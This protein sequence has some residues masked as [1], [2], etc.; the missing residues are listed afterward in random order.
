MGLFAVLNSVWR[1]GGSKALVEDQPASGEQ[2]KPVPRIKV[3]RPHGHALALEP[4][5]MFDG[6][7]ASAVDHQNGGD[8]TRPPE[9]PSA[10][11][12]A[13]PTAQASGVTAREPSATAEAAPAAVAAP[14]PSA[15]PQHLL[16]IDSRVE[17][18]EQLQAQTGP[19]VKV[20]VVDN[21]QD[22]LAAIS[23][24][25]AQMG[26]VDSIQILSHGG[27][28]QFTLGSRN[29]SADNIDQLGA[30]LQGWQPHLTADADIQLYG[31]SVGAGVAGQTLVD[32]LAR[33]TGA[34][35]GASSDATGAAADG[36]N[37][38]LETRAGD[39]DKPLVLGA[40][41]LATFDGLLADAMPQVSL[42]AGGDNV[43]LGDTFTFT[44]S[45]TNGSE[46]VGYAPYIDV[47]VPTTGKD[48]AGAEI[49][50]GVTLLSATFQGVQI[51]AYEVVFDPSGLATHPLAKGPDGQ[52][53]VI[54]AAQFGMRAGDTLWVLQLP[55]ASITQGQ[56]AID[57]VVTLQLSNL[58]DT[59]LTDT[60][61]DLTIKAR[62]GF[63]FGNTSA[64]DPTADPTLIEAVPHDFVVH[65]TMVD[66]TMTANVPEGQT[67]TGPNYPR[68][69]T[70]TASTASDQSLDDVVVGQDLP[71]DIIVTSIVP[72]TGGTVT[73]I[74]LQDGTVITD[75][76]AIATTLAAGAYLKH[77][78]VT[79][80]SLT[81]SVDTTVNFYV[82]EVDSD[83]TPVL[84]PTTGAP[85]TITIDGPEATAQWTPLDTRDTLLDPDAVLS[86]SGDP[87]SFQVLS[88]VVYKTPT[89]T[90]DT[91]T[92]GAS[93][94][95]TL[96]YTLQVDISDYFAFG[97]NVLNQ[98]TLVITDAASDGQTVVADSGRF[99]ATINGVQIDVAIAPASITVDP[100]TGVTTMTLDLAQTMR[101][102][103]QAL[104][105]LVG[106][107]AFD[108]ANDGATTATI[109]YQT[110]ID[111]FYGPPNAQSAIN[112][113]DTV[114][115]DATVS[116]T[117][118]VDPVT[119]G[120]T[121]SDNDTSTVTITPS[122]VDIEVLEVDDVDVSADPSVE[123]RPGN[124]VTFQVSY[125]LVTGDYQN[126]SLRVY[127][128]LPLFDVN[129]ITWTV[130][131]GNNQW[132]TGPDHTLLDTVQSVTSVADGNYIV[133]DF[134]DHSSL[135]NEGSR[136]ELRFTMTV[137]DTPFGDQRKVTVIAQSDQVTTLGDTHIISQ[138]AAVIDSIAEPV[139]N[140]SHGVVSSSN[141]TVTGAGDNGWT[142]PDNT[143]DI[144]FTAPVTEITDVNG[145]VSGIDG[146]D[147]LRMATAI[148]N[149]GG[150][151]AYDV[152][153]RIDLPPGLAF[154][155]AGLA[156]TLRIYR[157]DG[158]L[159]VA[160]T[161]YEVV[162]NVV[163]FLD[164]VEAHGS[165]LAGRPDTDPDN[166]GQN[167]VVLVYDVRVSDTIA[168]SSTL[169]TTATLTN[170][171]AVDEGQDF[172]PVDLIE[173]AGEQ[174]AAPGIT[175]VY[176]DGSLTDDDSSAT[177]TT[178]ANLVI[179]ETMDYDIVVTLPEG[180]TTNLRIDDLIPSGLALDM[181]FG[182][183]AGY[184]IILLQSQSGAL[185]ADFAGTIAGQTA[186]GDAVGTDGADA[187]LSFTASVNSAD[188][189]TGNNSFVIRVRLVASNSP[190][191][192]QGRSLGNSAQLVYEDPDGDVAGG[193]AG[194]RTV[195]L[196]SGTPSV[197]VVEPTLT[198]T[199][200]ADPLPQFGVDEGD[201]V[202]YTITIG[203]TSGTD[204]FDLAFQETFPTA[205]I[206][207][208]TL[209]SVTYT[210]PGGAT[211]DITASFQLVDG[212]LSSLGTADIDLP[213]GGT[214]VILV[215]GT[216]TA[217]A[218]NSQTIDSTA[219]VSWTS[220]D[221]TV[222]VTSAGGERT[223]A[224]GLLDTGVL[225]DYQAESVIRV[226]VLSGLQLS[227]IG[228]MVDTPPAD[229]GTAGDNEQ[230]AVGEIVRYRVVSA[231]GE[232]T[233]N[234][235]Q[236]RVVLD[237][238]LTFANDGTIRIAIVS[239]G[240]AASVTSTLLL[241][242]DGTLYV[243]GDRT[244]A[245]A[246]PIPDD[247]DGPAPTALIAVG[248]VIVDPTD[249][250]IVTF[251][252]GT[253][254]NSDGDDNLE[255][256]VI[257]FN[258]R[259]AN[260]ASN[261]AGAALG[262]TASFIREGGVVGA[263]DSATEIVVE[264]AFSGMVKQ[265]DTFD[266]VTTDGD[267]STA[268]ISVRFTQSGGAPAYDV[269]L[270]DS[271]AGLVG[272]GRY[273]P[274]RIS[275]GGTEYV[276]G[277]DTL[278]DG[279]AFT[280]NGDG[281]GITVTFDRI[282]Q[283]TEVIVYY[284]VAVDA[285][286]AYA[287]TDAVL[288]WSSL[289][290]SFQNLVGT[291]V[292]VDGAVDGERDGSEAGP[293][294][295]VLREGAGL[296]LIRGQLW[297]DSLGPDGSI[298][299]GEALLADQTVTLVWGGAD[300]VVGT[301]GDDVTFTTITDSAGFFQFSGL[302]AGGYQVQA[303]TP[304]TI[305]TPDLGAVRVRFDTDAN[306]LGQVDAAVEEGGTNAADFGYVQLNDAPVNTVP[307]A[308]QVLEDEVLA[309]DNG[310]I[311][312]VGDVDLDNGP[313]AGVLDVTL[314]VT[315]GM[316]N[317]SGAPPTDLITAG[318]LGGATITLSGTAAQ[319][320]DALLRLTYQGVANYNGSDV[321]RITTKD[322]GSF[323]DNPD[324]ALGD[325]IPGQLADELTDE[326]TV[327]INVQAVNDIPEGVN[328]AAIAVE[329]GGT[330]NQTPGRDPTGN[331]LDN[332]IDV[333]KAD[334]PVPDV[335][336]LT[337]VTNEDGTVVVLIDADDDSSTEHAIQGIHGTLYVRANGVARYVVDNDDPD[338]QALRTADDIRQ[339]TFTYTLADS[340][341]ADAPAPATLTVTIQGANDTPVGNDDTGTAV[342]GV[343]GAPGTPATGNV[344]LGDS[345]GGVADTDVD[346]VDFGET[347]RVTGIRN[348]AKDEAG[349]LVAVMAGTDTVIA[350]QYGTLT[351][352]STGA[353]TYVVNEDA[354]NSLPAGAT[355]QDV[356]SYELSD[357]GNLSTLANL[358]IT[359]VGANDAPLATDDSAT[360][361]EA[362][363]LDN[364]TPGSDGEGLALANDTDPDTG[365]T[366]QLTVT[367]IR[368]GE[369]L[370]SGTD[371]TVGTRLQGQYG[372]LTIQAD[373]SY[374]YEV[375]NDDAAVQALRTT[376]NTLLDYFTYT[377]GDRAAGTPGI[378]SDTA[379]IIITIQGANDTPVAND[380]TGTAI[381]GVNG[382]PGTPATGNVVLG[383][384]T[385]GVA[386]TDVDSV[387]NGETQR[388]SGIRTGDKAGA[389]GFTGVDG[390]AG[391]TVIAGQYGTLT[392]GASGAYTYVVDEDA[393]NSLPAGATLEDV[394][395]YQ[396]S[397]TGN[398]T[399]VAN[400]TIT[401][402]G[403]NDAPL[404]VDD[405]AVALEAGGTFNQTAGIDPQGNVLSNDSDPDTGDQLVVN[406]I[407][408]GT[409]DD[410]GPVTLVV[411]DTS[412][413][414]Q[415]GT[416]TIRGDGT[417]TYVVNNTL[418]AVQR[419][420]DGDSL[421]ETFSYHL[422]DQLFGSAV[423]QLVVTIDGA[424][425]APVAVD[426]SNYAVPRLI[427]SPGRDA[428]GN[429]IAG[430]PL[431]AGADSDVDVPD[432]S[433]VAGI[434]PG[435]EAVP[436]A[437]DGV[438]AG[439]TSADGTQVVGQYGRLTIG[440]DGSYVY[441][442]NPLNE[443]VLALQA[444]ESLIERFTYQSVDR[445]GLN[446]T[447]E[448]V[449][450]VFGR[451]NLPFPQPDSG[452][453]VE[454]GGLNND[455]PGV[456]PGG[457][458]LTNDIDLDPRDTLTVSAVRTGG[459]LE[460]G[461]DGVVGQPLRGTYG[462][463][464]VN[465][466]GTWTYTVDN[467]L[468]AVEALRTADQTL[469]ETFTYTASDPQGASR[470]AT[471]RIVIA[472][473]N[474][475]PIAQ[476]DGNEALEAGG[477]DNA[478]PGTDATGNVLDNDNDVDG[479]QYGETEQVQ[480]YAGANGA[481]GEAGSAVA[482]LYGQ[483]VINADGSYRYVI[484]N[485]N[486]A[487]Q[488]L[489]TSG[490]TL[491]E[492]FSYVMRDAAGA[493]SQANLVIVVRGAN[494]NPVARDDSNV[495]SDQV[496]APQAGGNVLPNDSDVDGGDA[497]HV[498]AV[499]TGAESGAGTTGALGQPLAGRYGTLVL[500]ADGSYTYAI[501][502]TN[503]EVLAAAGFGQILQDV[504]TYTV[505]DRA[506]ATDQ[507]QLVIHLDISAPRIDNGNPEYFGRDRFWPEPPTLGL[508][509]EPGL[510]V[511][512][513][514]RQSELQDY[515]DR[516]SASGTEIALVLDHYTLQPP[517]SFTY[518][519]NSVGGEFVGEVVRNN[520]LAA[521][522]ELARLLGRH[523][524]VS[525]TADGLLA[526][527]SLFSSS[528]ASL[529]VGP[530]QR[531]VPDAE[532]GGKRSPLA[533]AR[534]TIRVADAAPMP[535][536]PDNGDVQALPSAGDT[537]ALAEPVP[538]ATAS[539]FSEQL[540]RAAA[541]LHSQFF[542]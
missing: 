512:P 114:G 193:T 288:T 472:G 51:Q 236:I 308:Q 292:G 435:A 44:A 160:G 325:G 233:T 302:A 368:T 117:V 100:V 457:N 372:W 383:D 357:T 354:V 530:T 253:I 244:S 446:D 425:D 468:A 432:L 151:D 386:D 347:Q 510:F 272:A 184:E 47:F 388:V 83:G 145:D 18:R 164:P 407:R 428:V 317:F 318:T 327:D 364:T 202:N 248:R 167:L 144:P 23:D 219:N 326:D 322:R 206:S 333:D 376:G 479:V 282:D 48:G 439:T 328:D 35:V 79:Y 532:A 7:A 310:N 526:D 491:T 88:I 307:G 177:H 485:A 400:L 43:L 152:S 334:Q 137:S 221:D 339:E 291:D 374:V 395:S 515:T 343:N 124:V 330:N 349:D 448:L 390:S 271:F 338:V 270:V 116:G 481:Q 234:N 45:F 31:C 181:S 495:A 158:T 38:T 461:A 535:L 66:L 404:P 146:G 115:N 279:V 11:R 72:G 378:Q 465:A 25:L 331:L 75:T 411:G 409:R 189:D 172:T 482:G 42:S 509:V 311:I 240:G 501:D 523:G 513:V 430:G 455:R 382:A 437:F 33:W 224:D 259:V 205:L 235:Y 538:V 286:T 458:V 143:T 361:L 225:N 10:E 68:S 222:P 256:V 241:S 456:D 58:A 413:D 126:F 498:G 50:D 473:S 442:V 239:D 344:V 396:L 157:G 470:Q 180:T 5:V 406:G 360:A 476:D 46:Q 412:V 150:G 250:R 91:G 438:T 305:D 335:L 87:V 62:G 60:A 212:V 263:S 296:G 55:N 179:G 24:A 107:L 198:V 379:Q 113:G 356:F 147:T 220:L 304:V 441:V 453:A 489:R 27:A 520:A 475:T 427:D 74:T 192:Q 201:T 440:A 373:G 519:L 63:Q 3:L 129:G 92:P 452:D 163:T 321:L 401:I 138:D 14:A 477:I 199:Q 67:V 405:T 293:N 363:G 64:D 429:V 29:F 370:G 542:Q 153:T 478:T 257:E 421:T 414:G 226:P 26:Q 300:G 289:P 381:E 431:G 59:N 273:T 488:A 280:A 517:T 188:N 191:N 1:H 73:S 247:L 209:T 500:N 166:T 232:G 537:L 398:L 195:A 109:T 216:V 496:V 156:D 169:Q 96:T 69:I 319:I 251:D 450:T 90:D 98:G 268:D 210:A 309:F 104:A 15:A 340:A 380:D 466:D 541:Q 416:L 39:V 290:E 93:P 242:A 299:A 469:E 77:Y 190:E 121:A 49:D 56:P 462:T 352:G 369:E 460:S 182:G 264:P 474:D 353:Y 499:R 52:P 320:N 20:L 336:H 377:A 103:G 301:G 85:R 329:A 422:R 238:G 108:D 283:N 451:N 229:G 359:I 8:T 2:S 16:V 123:L 426:D 142:T 417:F 82:P 125:D 132:F 131:E 262:V 306:A 348:V 168:A 314:T 324:P 80:A 287:N 155:G 101:D 384:S 19:D 454:A 274:S 504:F 534:A 392:I 420:R 246:Q 71:N 161:D 54:N 13:A 217:E 118:L 312:S 36:G 21:S 78:E 480:A 313:T 111:Q 127:M 387:A 419:L 186:S 269:T 223:G 531:Q 278:P 148:E 84:D 516:L 355:L 494:D 467:S 402:V 258:A 367:A 397:D 53:L 187:R 483:I 536:A 275:I 28:G 57:I 86:G 6:A 445:G 61:P 521:Q 196:S 471:L 214:I 415:Y 444:G 207:G 518:G 237:E 323:G 128:P 249:S 95:D 194:D 447:A 315:H 245:I 298:G 4:R 135:I 533:Q 497:L 165:L 183:G 174:V 65:P 134:G 514:V 358:T 228:G 133:F 81:G 393:V 529:T 511:Q 525:L 218:D 408:A 105:A 267:G 175:K 281:T 41:T 260:I 403:A 141:G 285:N 30:Q 297:D 418:D 434:R 487:V 410:G 215:S 203:N 119:T 503:P 185:S 540:R 252:L 136:V 154:V 261:T 464:L 524:R 350:G 366:A 484:D 89:I 486:P 295:Y 459:L 342:E 34:D 337:S 99:V 70:V 139:L 436:G 97:R 507:A 110:T 94:G 522:L 505:V 200:T 539:A 102:N 527:P 371:G 227:R 32:E 463:L 433:T 303:P 443:E 394:F 277:V 276:I 490:E 294:T 508:Q 492:T 211:T 346:S 230:V 265:V 423:G 17:Q 106:D 208:M 171:A 40:E 266:P 120:E 528:A 9:A 316:L 506:G 162:D 375:N 243:T 22:G 385:G 399:A 76:G 345:T 176:R 254:T 12:S 149:S 231:I 159:L 449:I 341:G 493:V 173:L 37:W 122:Q 365:D 332:D 351:I 389:G 170:Y 424:W 284:T 204:A 362:G 502:L 140:I 130:G 255:G 197:V 178:G 391:D 213:D 112:E